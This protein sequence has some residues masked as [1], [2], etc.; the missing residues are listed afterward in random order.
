MA[1]LEPDYVVVISGR[2]VT[3]KIR[4][5][6]ES[7]TV[8]DKDG[9]NSDTC[10]I[11]LADP[12][13]SVVMPEKDDPITVSLGHK[14][15]GVGL[16]FQ[17]FVDGST[18]DGA[19]GSGRKLRINGKSA[20]Q[21]SK[22]KEPQEKHWDD[23]SFGDVAK[24]AGKIAGLEVQV[25]SALASIKRPYWSMKNESFQHWGQRLADELGATFKI[26]GNQ[27]VFMKRNAGTGAGGTALGT[28][29]AVWGDN[30]L[31]WS[32]SPDL[33]RPQFKK[34]KVR[35]YDPKEAKW[36]TEEREIDNTDAPAERTV[37]FRAGDK[38]NAKQKAEAEGAASERHKGSG[39]ATIIGDAAAKPEGTLVVIGA[40]PGIDGEYTIETIKHQVTKSQGYTC[41]I[42]IKKPKG[43][44]GKD[45]RGKKK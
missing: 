40:R 7:I 23:K 29:R 44:A 19:F 14:G 13:G 17:G 45:G 31:K 24:E 27:G 35:Y 4:P 10:D 15:R 41:D 36:K 16:V 8:N 34:V 11:V 38:D 1:F 9:V 42:T 21:K 6:V 32:I 37:R 30:L 33:G 2:D 20:K 12:D 43:K 26:V 28:V 39:S 18:S 5:L 3:S 25:N 22:G